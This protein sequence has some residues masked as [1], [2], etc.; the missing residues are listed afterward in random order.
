MTESVIT[1]TTNDKRTKEYNDCNIQFK[2]VLL[3]FTGLMVYLFAIGTIS[4]ITKALMLI[5]LYIMLYMDYN[6]DIRHKNTEGYHN[7]NNNTDNNTD[8]NMSKR[9]KKVIELNNGRNTEGRFYVNC[10]GCGRDRIMDDRLNDRIN[11]QFKKRDMCSR[12][13][14]EGSER[15]MSFFNDKYVDSSKIFCYNP[16]IEEDEKNRAY[17]QDY[18]GGYVYWPD[19]S[20]PV[21]GPPYI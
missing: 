12:P 18:G 7:M 6:M 9:Q 10:H 3:V 17:E 1:D 2:I 13:C 21:N 8:N 19:L 15:K 5:F 14:T 11:K 4:N 20:D 16:L